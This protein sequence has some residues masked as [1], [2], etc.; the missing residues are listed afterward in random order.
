MEA[1]KRWVLELR[2][3]HVFGTSHHSVL[4]AIWSWAKADTKANYLEPRTRDKLCGMVRSP[5]R[6]HRVSTIDDS[7]TIG[8]QTDCILSN[9]RARDLRSRRE[10]H[11]G[12]PIANIDLKLG[13]QHQYHQRAAPGMRLPLELSDETEDKRAV[14]P[15]AR[16]PRHR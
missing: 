11:Q 16:L 1:G 14:W 6:F 10:R 15:R 13:T 2:W 9:S 3:L 8:A 12:G 4:M 5:R 7:N